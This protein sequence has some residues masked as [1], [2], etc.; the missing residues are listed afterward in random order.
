[1]ENE[2]FPLLSEY[3]PAI[4]SEGG[5]DPLGLYPI[6][7]ALAE[8]LVP[9][10]RER[11]K[12][13]RFLTAMA[14]GA[15][16][17]KNFENDTVAADGISPP[18]QVFEWYV[19]EG[20]ARTAVDPEEILGVPGTEKARQ[21][22]KDN[23]P[24]SARR[25]LKNPSV[26]G[27]H[28][29]YR[30]LA[31]NMDIV[32]DEML[33]ETGHLLLT[34]WGKEQGL[35]GFVS[36]EAGEGAD[37][38]KQSIAALQDGLKAKGTARSAGWSG[39]AFFLNHLAPLKFGKREADLISKSLMSPSFDL[40]RETV[41]FLISPEGQKVWLAS[42][43]EREFHHALKNS[44]SKELIVL[45]DA[46]DKFEDYSRVLQDVFDDCLHQMTRKGTKISLKEL[47]DAEV[48][49]DAQRRILEL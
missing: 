32:R 18:W 37:A 10:V 14:L 5:L 1:M 22:I 41:H 12:H 23:V 6:A 38:R 33:G 25:Y 47:A 43:S 11:Q 26:F 36:E 40:R 9:A 3:D 19:V 39:W 16:L 49:K 29:V 31:E 13:P 48:I 35:K 45:L 34:T 15:E 7:D 27:F 4:S 30:V 46:I 8:F 17:C 20:M 42:G 24:L 44:A 2:L 21:A 28:G